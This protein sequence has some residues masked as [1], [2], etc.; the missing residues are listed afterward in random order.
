MFLYGRYVIFTFTTKICAVGSNAKLF[1]NQTKS[2]VI[3]RVSAHYNSNNPLNQKSNLNVIRPLFP[4]R[5]V[6]MANPHHH[7]N[8]KL[9][10]TMT[11]P[12]LQHNQR[13]CGDELQEQVHPW[14]VSGAG[15]LCAL[16]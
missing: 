4:T 2:K 14:S 16:N 15:P 10:I 3:I 9:S 8:H 12:S 6:Y 13:L 5:E 7:R 11:S 1:Q